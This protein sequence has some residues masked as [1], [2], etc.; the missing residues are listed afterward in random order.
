MTGNGVVF[1]DYTSKALVRALSRCRD[2][3][4][5]KEAFERLSEKCMT[6]DFS[7]QESAKQYKDMYE[8]L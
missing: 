3:Y 8:S 7:W 6:Y 1:T 2:I 4:A 5:Q